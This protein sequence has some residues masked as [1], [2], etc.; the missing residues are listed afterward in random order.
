MLARASF[1]QQ[2]VSS[3]HFFRYHLFSREFEPHY[4]PILQANVTG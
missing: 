3:L 2:T 1:K 4:D